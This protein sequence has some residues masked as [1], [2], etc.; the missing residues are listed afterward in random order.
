MP[1]LNILYADNHLLVVDKPAGLSTMG[2]TLGE[3]TLARQ[4]AEYL[5]HKHNKPGNA[6]IGVVSRLDRLVSG[7]LVLA[8]TSKAAS[9]VSEQIR[10]HQVDKFYMAIVE[11]QWPTQLST[12]N[13]WHELVDWVAK[14]EASHRMRV[15]PETKPGA[16]LAH[17][18]VQCLANAHD[19]SLLKIELMTGRKHQIRLQ[20]AEQGTPVWGDTKYGAARPF[21]PGI[22]LHCQQLTILHPTLKQKLTFAS[23]PTQ[24]WTKVPLEF[25]RLIT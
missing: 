9:R 13:S 1:P 11:G 5:R 4:A 15:V 18:R 2:S 24:H 8:R 20:L 14:D 16:Q 6:F 19:K 10:Q 22:A 7:V 17:M 3:P 21:S 12:P 23:P 25:E